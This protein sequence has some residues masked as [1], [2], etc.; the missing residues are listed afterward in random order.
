MPLGGVSGDVGLYIYGDR[1]GPISIIERDPLIDSTTA[2]QS[3]KNIFMDLWGPAPNVMKKL[4]DESTATG[5]YTVPGPCVRSPFGKISTRAMTVDDIQNT[6][7]DLPDKSLTDKNNPYKVGTEAL[8]GYCETF[9][10]KYQH[11]SGDRRDLDGRRSFCTSNPHVNEIVMGWTISS[12]AQRC[13]HGVETA[14]CIYFA[15]EPQIDTLQDLMAGV[16]QNLDTTVVVAPMAWSV[17]TAIESGMFLYDIRQTPGQKLHN[18]ETGMFDRNSK[19]F[20]QVPPCGGP[21]T[22]LATCRPQATAAELLLVENIVE[23][24]K[25][26]SERDWLDRVKQ[27]LG[28]L[29]DKF[30]RSPFN[31]Q[32]WNAA[33]LGPSGADCP[34]GQ[35]LVPSVPNSLMGADVSGLPKTFARCV[36]ASFMKPTLIGRGHT[37]NLRGTTLTTTTGEPI[38]MTSTDNPNC[39]GIIIAAPRLTVD[40][41]IQIDQRGCPGPE[42]T[43]MGIVIVGPDARNTTIAGIQMNAPLGKQPVPV[44]ALG[45]DSVYGTKQVVNVTGLIANVTAGAANTFDYAFAHA[46]SA[47]PVTLTV[48]GSEAPRVLLQEARNEHFAVDTKWYLFN[49]T[50]FTSV[51][52]WGF[53]SKLYHPDTRPEHTAAVAVAVGILIGLVLVLLNIVAFMVEKDLDKTQGKRQP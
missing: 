7:I 13:I 35:V 4:Q 51:F 9:G 1:Q 5:Y 45:Y 31:T 12:R 38:V 40:V 27:T 52:G 34:D 18:S 21:A 6:F 36:D 28:G 16:P 32:K 8:I 26:V 19:A 53:E 48:S 29:F 30:N 24:L 44:A 42:A 39:N 43:M 49:V 23:A 15:Y 10:A 2:D 47:T 22:K 14:V 50:E 25:G 37:I 20:K 3:F 41:P 11:C 33:V 17:V 46:V